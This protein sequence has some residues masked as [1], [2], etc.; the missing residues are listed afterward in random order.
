MSNA[1]RTY[2]GS[3]LEEILPRIRVELGADAVI[4]RRRE[5]LTGGVGG[6]FQKQFVEVEAHAGSPR[7]EVV[8][9]SGAWRDAWKPT[10]HRPQ[11]AGPEFPTPNPQSPISES[12]AAQPPGIQRIL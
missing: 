1:T 5:G 6:F 9:H 11:P 4:T 12:P 8:V 3:S 7:F 10:G 2:R